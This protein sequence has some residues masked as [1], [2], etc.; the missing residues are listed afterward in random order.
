MRILLAEDDLQLGDLIVQLLEKSGFQVDWV[1]DGEQAVDYV[2]AS[3][4]NIVLLDWMMPVQD[5]IAACRS[6]RKQGVQTPIVMLTAKDAVDDRIQGLDA[7]ADDYIIKPFEFTE[8]L[9][10]IRALSRRNY[11]P[12]IS[13]TVM[14]RD[15]LLNRTSQALEKE[16][17]TI[18][19]SPR[20]YQLLDLFV[21][22]QGQVLTRE[23]IYERI[24]GYDADVTFKTIDATVKLLRKKLETVGLASV[25][26]SIRGVGYRFE[27]TMDATQT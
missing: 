15:V 13:Q 17:L 11:A 20:E 26:S 6:L 21:Q 12:I 10:R 23:V 25:I 4:Y 24:W 3:H 1:T 9:A 14:L 8:L 5:G 22:N 27:K 18:L 19:L 7:G 2:E 16:D